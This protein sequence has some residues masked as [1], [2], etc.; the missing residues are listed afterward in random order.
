LVRKCLSIRFFN[1][2]GAIWISQVRFIK[3]LKIFGL[4]FFEGAL[5]AATMVEE[6]GESEVVLAVEAG[7]LGRCMQMV[8]CEVQSRR[9]WP[10]Q[11]NR[12]HG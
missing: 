5:P 1:L 6:A 3:K 4:L 12:S 7:G 10:H 8:I 9:E 11:P 2:Q